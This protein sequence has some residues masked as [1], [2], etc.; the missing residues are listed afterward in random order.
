MSGEKVVNT[1]G[2][3]DQEVVGA[4]LPIQRQSGCDE[5]VNWDKIAQLDP[6]MIVAAFIRQ[7]CLMHHQNVV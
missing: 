4:G 7:R 1:Y 6:G 2:W 3:H 5:R